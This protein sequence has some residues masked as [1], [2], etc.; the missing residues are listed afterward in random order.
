[1]EPVK[2]FES[3]YAIKIQPFLDELDNEQSSVYNW[4]KFTWFTGAGAFICLFLYILKLFPSGHILAGAML[5]MCI[6]GVLFWTRYSD[7]Y[8]DDFKEKIIGQ[9]ITYIYPSA[10]Y[11]P[12]GFISKKEYKASGLYRRR[13]SNFDGDDYWQSVYNGVAFHCSEIT[14]WYEDVAGTE[15]IFK[16]LFFI[17]RINNSF[18]GGTYIWTRGHA[19][20]PSSMADEHYRMFPLPPVRK[21][22]VDHENFNRHYSVYT[23]NPDEASLILSYNML[24]HILLIREKLQREIVFSFVRGK[25]YIAVPFEENLLEPPKK[26]VRDKQEIK[27]YFY[28]ILLV[29]NIIR[30]LEL[31]RLT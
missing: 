22:K 17:A 25:C 28:T 12:M 5:L 10:V 15:S 9:I 16:G 8:I 23:T 7:R 3:F 19:Q 24:D 26:G 20:L 11:K 2:D 4:K 6:T 18:S 14:S 29:F 21:M 31:N 13:F 27:N 30:K 1:M